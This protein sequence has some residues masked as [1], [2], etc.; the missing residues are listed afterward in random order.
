MRLPFTS[1]FRRRECRLAV[2]IIFLVWLETDCVGATVRVATFNLE[3][4]LVMDRLVAGEWRPE[5]PKPEAEKAA[6]RRVIAKVSPDVLAV[7]EI[8][9]DLFLKE[10]QRDLASEK[11]SYPYACELEG[12]DDERRIAVLSRLPFEMIRTHADLEFP[13]FGG[14][15]KIRRGL[16]EVDFVTSGERWTL[17]VVHL[18]SKWTERPDDP[19]AERKRVGEAT[20]ARDAIL[21]RHDPRTGARYLIA[22]DFNDT[23]AAS[24]LQRLLKRGDVTIAEMIPATDSHGL[25]WTH[26]WERQGVYSQVD[27]LLASPALAERVAGGRGSIHDGPFAAEASDHRLVW[28]D[29]N[30]G[31][32][33]V[34]KRPSRSPG[35]RAARLLQWFVTGEGPPGGK[36]FD[37]GQP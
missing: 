20:A 23:R 12:A 13:Y 33:V 25:T 22:G 35:T 29:L 26:H 9:P 7:Q 31:D 15:E 37:A 16:L 11:L 36:P 1:F 8:G 30:F 21:A 34:L 2:G 18:K 24:T 10:L 14:R 32:D 4:Y 28:A 27:Y 19:E 3:N 5:Y 17:Y 6:L